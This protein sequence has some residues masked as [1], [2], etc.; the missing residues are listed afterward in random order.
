MSTKYYTYS[1]IYLLI[2]FISIK[3]NEILIPFISKLS[4]IPKDLNPPKFIESLLNNKFYIYID[5]GTPPQKIQFLVDFNNYDS[6]VVHKNKFD[7]FSSSTFNKIKSQINY[8]SNDYRLS[9]LASD[10]VS[11][12]KNISNFNLTFLYVISPKKEPFISYPGILGF[13]VSQLRNENFR[14]SFMDQLKEKRLIKNYQY[15]LIF[16]DDDFNGKIILEKDIYEDYPEDLLVYD[17]SMFSSE[18]TYYYNWGWDYMFTY[19]NSILLEIKN[20][21][22][23][24]ELGLI[25]ASDKVKNIFREKFF[26]E[27]IKRNKCFESYYDNYYFYRCEK[28]VDINE[29]GKI[30][31]LI[32]LKD[33][34]ITLISKDLFY[35]YN[36]NLYFLIIFKNDIKIQ[37]IYLGRPFFKKYNTLFNPDSRIVG[38]YNLKIDYDYNI[39]E[40]KNDKIN[41]KINNNTNE[42]NINKDKIEGPTK[43]IGNGKNK[44][45]MKKDENIIYKLIFIIA[46]II[47][48]IIILLTCFYLY[49]GIKR[50]R[51]RK[52]NFFEELNSNI[53]NL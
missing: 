23:Q 7:N 45:K 21:F 26:E 33:I 30:E 38:F 15:T 16:N 44:D 11:F 41:K 1:I 50:K 29:F 53:D 3:D 40:E 10:V 28:E 39:Q 42:K 43:V 32:K 13:G 12:E 19:Y 27:K 24:P 31:F 46:L 2:N 49:R 9:Y 34:N 51:K 22:L 37:D 35:E 6:F 4:E 20:I 47:G 18:F 36:N 5:I 48:I 8:Y 17:Y 14:H 25:I 52:G